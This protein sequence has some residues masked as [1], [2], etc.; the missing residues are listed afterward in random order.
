MKA[1]ASKLNGVRSGLGWG[2]VLSTVLLILCKLWLNY[3]E[4]RI[5]PIGPGDRS[6]T[7]AVCNATAILS[8]GTLIGFLTA[9]AL[10]FVGTRASG[11]HSAAKPPPAL[12]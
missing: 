6:L 10:I 1:T 7:I 4:G 5:L 11:A 9:T 3:Y 2:F 8:I 12:Q